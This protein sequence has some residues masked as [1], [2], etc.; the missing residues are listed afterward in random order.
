MKL[1]KIKRK[2]SNTITRWTRSSNYKRKFL[3]F[4]L[5]RDILKM[6]KVTIK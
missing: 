5:S 3:V 2:F 4:S 1:K 6:D